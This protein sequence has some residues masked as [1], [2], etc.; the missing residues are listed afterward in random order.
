[1]LHVLSPGLWSLSSTSLL[2][3]STWVPLI[4][5]R[6]SHTL[7]KGAFHFAWLSAREL[8]QLEQGQVNKWEKQ[9]HLS[10][11]EDSCPQPLTGTLFT[12]MCSPGFYW[13]WTKSLMCL[14]ES[15]FTVTLQL[16]VWSRRLLQRLN[17]KGGKRKNTGKLSYSET[18]K[19]SRC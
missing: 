3:Q 4:S 19:R 9:E 2:A 18:F 11:E 7:G 5:F 13:L 6:G 10:L 12:S 15:F 14:W 1:M 17:S 16:T 8:V